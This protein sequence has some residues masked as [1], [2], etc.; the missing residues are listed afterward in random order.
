MLVV[1]LV[2]GM[3]L[4]A[5]TM[6]A[7]Q[8]P[9]DPN[10]P[11]KP[12]AAPKAA[13]PNVETTATPYH[14]IKQFDLGGAGG[15]DYIVYDQVDNRLYVARGD[16]VAVVDAAT[17]KELAKIAGTGIHGTAV[18][19]DANVGFITNGKTNDVTVFDIKTFK[20]IEQVKTGTG[21]DAIHYDAATKTVVVSCNKGKQ[22]SFIPAAAA[23]GKPREAMT[24]DVGG[25]PEAGISDGEG[26]SYVNLE[27]THEVIVLDDKARKV[28]ARYS[29][30]PE[31]TPVGMAM[32][33]KNRILF[34]SCRSGKMVI[35]NADTGKIIATLPIGGGTDA[36]AFDP[37]T[38]RAF[39]SGGAAPGTVSIIQMESPTKFSVLQHLKT[40]PKAK[41]MALNSK[42]HLIYT[43]T[44][45]DNAS[46]APSFQVL[47]IGK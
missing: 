8:A 31:K 47:V 25:A 34:S 35:L 3:M 5:T 21:P 36:A 16:H 38:G 37:A 20:P 30:A 26:H 1:A 22:I 39:S 17:G 13:V 19:H 41:T 40:L 15:W 29:V 18:S 28:A 10:A 4:A 33:V 43:V 2:A 11:A 12:A 24:I 9:A 7:A 6:A 27:D 46:G 23:A 32:D 45:A 44:M 42:D 14:I